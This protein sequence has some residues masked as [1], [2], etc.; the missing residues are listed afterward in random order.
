MNILNTKPSLIE[1][2]LKD[3]IP[4]HLWY[5][6]FYK[7]PVELNFNNVITPKVKRQFS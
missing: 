7:K 3:R 5:K 6:Y 1:L 4:P 2:R